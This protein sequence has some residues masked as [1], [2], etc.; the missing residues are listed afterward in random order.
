VKST[1]ATAPAPTPIRRAAATAMSTAHSERTKQ[2]HMDRA[3]AWPSFHAVHTQVFSLTVSVSSVPHREY[4]DISHLNAAFLSSLSRAVL[5]CAH[6]YAWLLV[7]L[8]LLLRLLA[9]ATARG[10]GTQPDNAS[11][12]ER[13]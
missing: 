12:G 10:S 3:P 7:L 13:Q 2:W 8:R 6:I 9:V 4:M 11:D 1:T 5:L